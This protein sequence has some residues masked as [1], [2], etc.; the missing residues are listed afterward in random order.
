M[1]GME[2]PESCVWAGVKIARAQRIRGRMRLV[3]LIIV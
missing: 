3:R 2:M 1:L